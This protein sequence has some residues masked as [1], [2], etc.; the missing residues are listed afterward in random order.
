MK[1]IILNVGRVRQQFIK[2]GEAE[3]LKR[4]KGPW[5]I[6]LQEL[7]LEAPDSLSARQ[8][9]EQEGDA[10]LKRIKPGEFVVIL[11]ERGKLIS[12]Q[13]FSAYCAQRMNSGIKT[14]WFVIGGAHGFS[15]KVRARADYLLAL[16]PMTFP[17]QLTRLVLIEQLYRS[18]TLQQGI[19]YH[20]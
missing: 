14:L 16:S 11:D 18:Y 13:E 19:G 3:Y 6:E 20:K 5:G 12:S 7:G 8:V 9:Q 4:L 10:V 15:D 1:I 17:H 2:D